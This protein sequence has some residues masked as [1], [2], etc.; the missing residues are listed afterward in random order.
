MIEMIARVMFPLSL[1]IAAAL[2][3]KGY[4][5]IGDGFSAGAVAG[6]GAVIQYVS[7]DHQRAA[8][9]VG[10]AWALRLIAIGLLLMLA[11]ALGPALVGRP[12]VSHLPAPDG[13]VIALGSLELHTAIL[14]DLGAGLIVYGGIVATFDR[15][16]PVWSG[17][18]P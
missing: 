5:D 12:P 18:E 4:S 11:V 2:W 15:L 6:L 14:F 13:H 7:L 1:V 9:A 17:E 8:R 3:I 10:A 16:F